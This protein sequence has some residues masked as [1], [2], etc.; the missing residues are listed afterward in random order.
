M[1]S[2]KQRSYTIYLMKQDIQSATDSIR[3]GAPSPLPLQLGTLDSTVSLYP[4]PRPSRPPS[5][6]SVFAGYV[7]AE[8]FGTVQSSAAVLLLP[9]GGRLFAICFGQGKNLLKP[10]SFEEHFGLR[11]ALN[12]IGR[13]N[14][15]SISKKSFDEIGKNSTEQAS[16]E[17]NVDSFGL[18]IEQDLLRAVSGTPEDPTLGNRMM[19]KDAL[20]VSVTADLKQLPELLQRYLQKYRDDS[21]KEDY[22]WVDQIEEVTSKTRELDLFE[23]L[24]G[25]VREGRRQGIWMAVPEILAWER[26][27]GFRFRKDKNLHHDVLFDRFLAELKD[28]ESADVALFRRKRVYCEDTEGEPF[29]EWSALQCLNAEVGIDGD[30]YVLSNGKWYKVV[31]DF[32]EQV[33]LAF[34]QMPEYSHPLPVYKDRNE[35]EYNERAATEMN[36]ALM[37]RKLISCGA[38]H[39]R[40]EFCDLYTKSKEIVHVK[41][42]GDS[43]VFSH[44]FNQGQTS[45]EL[46]LYDAGFREEVNRSLPESFRIPNTKETPDPIDFP[47]VFAVIS[48]EPGVLH[49]PFFSR[50]NLRRATN[51]LSHMRFKVFLAKIEKDPEFAMTEIAPTR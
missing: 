50:I 45:A 7:D 10:D 13:E 19:G 30:T 11:V 48:G 42:Y 5:W 4:R 29:H 17:S 14:I 12:S 16:L 40:I 20:S 31:T 39:R 21:Y 41:H 24:F 15:R 44:F 27:G 2:R 28:P 49:L 37:D 34:E 47:I 38:G 6:A 32:V 33:D 18:D 36:F 3:D 43:K 1:A 9:A 26:V 23:M 51:H 22:P 46:F 8:V 25:A 35:A